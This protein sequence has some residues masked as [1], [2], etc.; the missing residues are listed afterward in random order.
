[1]RAKKIIKLWKEYS[2]S[3]Y[4]FANFIKQPSEKYVLLIDQTFGDLSNILWRSKKD[5]FNKMFDFACKNWPN[6]KIVIKV[7][8]D[9]IKSK[10]IGCIDKFF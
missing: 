1:M 3:K 5:S 10:K 6:H 4:N 7:H 9:V 8:P 2:I